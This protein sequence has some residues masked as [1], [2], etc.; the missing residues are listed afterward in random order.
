M[1]W[2][3]ISRLKKVAPL[4]NLVDI[5]GKSFYHIWHERMGNNNRA[6]NKRLTGHELNNLEFVVN[7][8]TWG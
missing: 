8:E 1:E 2:E 3:F 4:Y 7:D 6:G 5:I